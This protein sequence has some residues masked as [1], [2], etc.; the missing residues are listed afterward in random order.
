MPCGVRNAD[1]GGCMRGDGW[2]AIHCGVRKADG[3][4]SVGSGLSAGASLGEMGETSMDA[5]AKP[6]SPVEE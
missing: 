4:A 5:E 6:E 3:G 2:Y 1:M